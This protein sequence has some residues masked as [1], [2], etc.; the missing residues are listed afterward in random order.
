MTVDPHVE[1][2]LCHSIP[3]PT[4]APP[5]NKGHSGLS[6][7]FIPWVEVPC[8]PQWGVQ[9]SSPTVPASLVRELDSACLN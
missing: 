7:P 5:E 1:G 6:E 9:G 8:G 4:S 3:P 2:Q